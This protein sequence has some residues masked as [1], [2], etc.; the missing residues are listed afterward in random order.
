MSMLGYDFANAKCKLKE[1]TER[2]AAI[3]ENANLSPELRSEFWSLIAAR[4][5]LSHEMET[6][7]ARIAIEQL[8]NA[9]PGD[10]PWEVDEFLRFKPSFVKCETAGTPTT[11]FITHDGA[12][13]CGL[14]QL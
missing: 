11:D 3:I 8:L 6:C 1:K 9:P 13:Q 7:R 10:V 4:S 2:L 14:P 5:M 12:N